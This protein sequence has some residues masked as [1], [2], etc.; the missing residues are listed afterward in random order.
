MAKCVFH[1]QRTS[2]MTKIFEI[3]H[4]MANLATLWQNV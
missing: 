1:D 2:Q 4:E 3:A